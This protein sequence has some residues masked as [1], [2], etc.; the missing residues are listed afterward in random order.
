MTGPIWSAIPPEVHSTLL[1]AGPG[2]GPLLAAATQWHA[3]SIQYS[4][5]AAELTQILAAVQAGSWTGPSAERYVAAHGPYLSWLE[6]A[7]ADSAVR[8]GQHE[9]AAAAYSSALAIMP[10]PE[11]L[12]ANHAVH[13]V[14]LATNFFGLNTIP[15]ALN[16]ADY[17]RMWVQ[18]SETMA[19]YEAVTTSAVS[20]V[21]QSQPSPPILAPGGEM[22]NPQTQS[23]GAPS[24]NNVSGLLSD[25]IS[26]AGDPEQLLQTFQ[27]FFEQLGFNP[28]EAAILAVVGLFLYD[29]LWY[30]YYASYSLLLLPFFAPALSALS[31]LAALG[32]LPHPQT[33]AAGSAE[34]PAG[35]GGNH[36]VV[37]T[38]DLATS[39]SP[40]GT[41]SVTGSGAE[42][43]PGVV[44]DGGATGATVSLSPGYLVPGF[45][46]PATTAGPRSDA[47]SLAEIPAASAA[48]AATGSAIGA[49][50]RRKRRARTRSARN[51]R[52]E[53]LEAPDLD[54]TAPDGDMAPSASDTGMA[55]FGFSGVAPVAAGLSAAGLIQRAEGAPAESGPMLPTTWV[56]ETDS[57]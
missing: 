55:T 52:Y 41:T 27:Q 54:G 50:R 31:A 40:P 26:G 33:A 18:A 30:P 46:P 15:I 22:S 37:P 34:E 8:A 2:P 21:P 49:A 47:T 9:T 28:A 7:S 6:H 12:A 20:A 35:G 14:L 5:A 38:A 24:Q 1:R 11:E 57:E 19:T 23:S 39:L 32:Q 45:D 42:V 16:E 53:F 17:V 51:H 3:L 10:T 4:S 29:V 44:T 56:R 48:V 13:G 43:H 25:L 36:R